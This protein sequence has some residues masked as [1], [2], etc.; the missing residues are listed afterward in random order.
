MA[1]PVPLTWSTDETNYLLHGHL[2]KHVAVVGEMI[3]IDNMTTI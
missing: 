2:V 3:N 1:F